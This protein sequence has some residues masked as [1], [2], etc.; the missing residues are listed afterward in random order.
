[1]KAE[2]KELT[3]LIY[4]GS[5]RGGQTVGLLRALD[6]DPHVPFS[7]RE[8]LRARIARLEESGGKR[9]TEEEYFIQVLQSEPRRPHTHCQHP[10]HWGPSQPVERPGPEHAVL[11][12]CPECGRKTYVWEVSPADVYREPHPVVASFKGR[13]W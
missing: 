6:S 3:R 13:S 7:M 12:T 11:H 8:E 10:E 4:G 9:T 5:A 1:M 2:K